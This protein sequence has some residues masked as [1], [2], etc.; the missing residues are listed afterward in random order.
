[1][2][3][4]RASSHVTEPKTSVLPSADQPTS[5]TF[6]S[7]GATDEG[8]PPSAD[9]NSMAHGRPGVAD[10]KAICL[11]SGDQRGNSTRPGGK[12]SWRRS[13]PSTLLRHNVPSG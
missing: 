9:T 8:L 4:V 12:V 6:N 7:D 5:P 1:M 11:P 10:A 13:L 2:A 3:M